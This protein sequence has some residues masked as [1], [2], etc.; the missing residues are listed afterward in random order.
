MS[1]ITHKQFTSENFPETGELRVVVKRALLPGGKL[2]TKLQ[3]SC[4]GIS[5]DEMRDIARSIL[6]Q[7]N[8]VEIRDSMDESLKSLLNKTKA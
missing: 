5:I 6:D 1:D 8:E 4:D 7:A 3:L 2:K